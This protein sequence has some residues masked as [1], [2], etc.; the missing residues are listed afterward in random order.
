MDVGSMDQIYSKFR[1]AA[2]DG[3]E[4]EYATRP[5][6]PPADQLA[7]RHYWLTGTIRE[8]HADRDQTPGSIRLASLKKSLCTSSCRDMP[9]SAASPATCSPGMTRVPGPSGAGRDHQQLLPGRVPG[10]SA[11]AQS[12]GLPGD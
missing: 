10:S 9:Y 1:N 5:D 7:E 3:I 6:K 12:P 8:R 4:A 2:H 11:A